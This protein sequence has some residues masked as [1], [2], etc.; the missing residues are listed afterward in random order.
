M[1]LDQSEYIESLAKYYRIVDSKL[2][3]TPTRLELNVGFS[4]GP[5]WI[6]LSQV[7]H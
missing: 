6:A 4:P 2:Y 3:N 5:G 1:T 7:G